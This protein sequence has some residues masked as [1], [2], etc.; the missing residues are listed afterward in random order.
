MATAALDATGTLIDDYDAI[1]QVVQLY[2]DGSA[3]GDA[4]KLREAFHPDARMFGS[5]GGHRYDVPIEELFK[6]AAAEP[7]DTNGRYRGRVTAVN[8]VGHAAVATVAEDGCWGSVSFVDFF[9]LAKIDG[10]WKI[11]NK[12][13]AHTGGAPPAG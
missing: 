11:V 10:S 3:K 5:L 7:M 8:Q 2:I 12:T 9:A 13:F 1:T 6:L 4:A